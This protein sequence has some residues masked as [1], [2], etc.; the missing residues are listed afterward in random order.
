MEEGRTK[1][2]AAAG[3]GIRYGM[4]VALLS[5]LA[6]IPILYFELVLKLQDFSSSACI[7][8]SWISS[9]IAIC[10]CFLVKGRNGP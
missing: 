9:C 6:R 7:S 10:Q 1:D 4:G 8:S 3:G 5:L 2:A